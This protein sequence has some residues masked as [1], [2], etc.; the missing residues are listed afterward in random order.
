[1]VIDVVEGTAIASLEH[2]HVILGKRP[3]SFPSIAAA[4]DWS[5]HS[6]TVRN[7]EAARVSIPSQVVQR[8]NGSFGWRTDLKSS[9]PF[10]RDWF[11]G[12]SEQFLSIPLPKILVLAGSDRLDTALT[13]G[14]MQ[15]KFELRLLYG[16]GHVI[17]E[18]CPSKLVEAILEFCGRCSL[19]VG[20]SFR[21]GGAVKSA[22]EI[23]AEKLAKA[24]AMVPK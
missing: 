10:W 24:R 4:I 16:T 20:G 15:G 19:S 22:S 7:P 18:D 2:M 9:A 12:L 5:L 23:L 13:R 21:P 17:Q 6:G 8:S 11:A 14:Q 1:M 3:Q